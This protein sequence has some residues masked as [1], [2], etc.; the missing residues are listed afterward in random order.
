MMIWIYFFIILILFRFVLNIIGSD[1]SN[2]IILYLFI[3]SFILISVESS[4]KLMYLRPLIKKSEMAIYIGNQSYYYMLKG[5]VN[6][7]KY[8]ILNCSYNYIYK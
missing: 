7:N 6:M 2:S 4:I 1:Y 3:L 8:L 5:Y